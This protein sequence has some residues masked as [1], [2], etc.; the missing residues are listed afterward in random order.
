MKRYFYDI[1]YH[2]FDLSHANLMAFML[3]DDLISK[4]AVKSFIG[5]LPFY[6]QLISPLFIKLFAGK[7]ANKARDFMSSDSGFKEVLSVMENAIEYH[8]LTVDYLLRNKEPVF[9]EN[10]QLTI[11]DEFKYDKIVLC[12]L[13]IDFGY[14][15][16]NMKNM[17]YNMPAK[18]PIVNQMVDLYNA[19]YFY[20]NFDLSK[21]PKKDYR[22]KAR[23]LE[24]S[25]KNERIFEFY[26]FLGINTANYPLES[27]K[28][29]FEKYFKGYDSD[30]PAL[31]RKRLYEK[32]GSE[33]L[34]VLS[35]SDNTKDFSYLFAGVKLYPPL[36]FDPLPKSKEEREKVKFLYEFCLKNNLP[37]I[38]HCSQGGFKT[39][40][41]GEQYTNP[42]KHWARVL[43]YYPELKINFAHFGDQPNKKTEWR[44]VILDQ[45][46]TYEN[47]YSDI[48]C[49]A[50]EPKFYK[51]LNK[52]LDKDTK[53]KIMFGT[54][55]LINLLWVKSYND[56][57]RLFAEDKYIDAK[58]K[59][60]ICS[61]NC[62]KFLF[63]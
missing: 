4:R 44:D 18:K 52:C 24:K 6:A 10:N 37:I 8:F 58:T 11:S 57:L 59:N 14:K 56:Y 30:T 15:N 13:M 51:T 50:T 34:D 45:C 29:L 22:L 17:F 33:K 62:E 39:D 19:I 42:A 47:V 9:D 53:N 3:R 40:K 16:L 60:M 32:I 25:S 28:A 41:N 48:S 7:V 12:P 35:L 38:T 1:H 49:V 43:K 27:I 63:G 46:R 20:Y 23:S 5:K 2:A 26:P 55:F 21:H 61:E 36:G 54:D 31:R